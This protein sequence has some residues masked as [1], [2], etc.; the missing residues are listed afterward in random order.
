M[1]RKRKV[2]MG[3]VIKPAGEEKQDHL[4]RVESLFTG[5]VA[6]IRACSDKELVSLLGD[7]RP[8]G[9]IDWSEWMYL[10]RLVVKELEGRGWV[11]VETVIWKRRG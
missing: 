5:A 7:T 10:K 4:G 1:G 2:G 8:F 3:K 9:D 6:K 11:R